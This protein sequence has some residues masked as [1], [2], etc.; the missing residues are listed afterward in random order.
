MRLDL[1][2]RIYLASR[3][4]RRRDLLH[5]IHVNFEIVLFRTGLREDVEV[6]EDVMAGESPA[7]YVLRIAHAKALAGVERVG[8][9]RLMPHPVLA[10]DTTIELDGGIIGKP[11]S[12]EHAEQILA[13]LS[14]RAHQV[15]TAIAVADA[16][17]V[18]HQLC[19]SQVRFRQLDAAE[20]RRYVATG[21]P[22]D[23]AGAYAIQ[24]RAGMLISEMH[25]S[26]SGIMG[27]P[28]YETSML[29]AK[30]GYRF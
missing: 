11:D 9:R 27:L 5:Q 19:V 10:A 1:Q 18:E 28:L 3:S 24:G 16:D 29:L 12:A 13:N 14:G 15:L 22:M 2:S 30:F 17:Y 20:I 21:E 23:K 6:C 25:G 26:Y 7:D 8:S 4:P